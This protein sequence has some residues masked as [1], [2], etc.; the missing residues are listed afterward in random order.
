MIILLYLQ[1][2][3]VHRV[4]SIGLCPPS[5]QYGHVYTTWLTL[6]SFRSIWTW[7]L[8][9]LS[10]VN[11]NTIACS[12]KM[13][14][15]NIKVTILCLH[16]GIWFTQQAKAV[17]EFAIIYST[18]NYPSKIIKHLVGIQPV[19]C[20]VFYCSNSMEKKRKKWTI[21]TWLGAPA[22]PVFKRW[23]YKFLWLQLNR[24]EPPAISYM[25]FVCM[26]ITPWMKNVNCN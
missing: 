13:L 19:W 20:S 10:R 25:V 2:N 3:W 21:Y 26:F 14:Y 5:Q 24:A 1:L 11:Q 12:H 8:E 23:Q 16:M 15:P 17:S 22:H 7:S 4:W 18:T 6:P 9:T